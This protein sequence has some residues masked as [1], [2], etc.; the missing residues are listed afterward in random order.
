MG[1]ITR[2]GAMAL[3]LGAL[4]APALAQARTVRLVVPY[5][6]GGTTDITGR[7]IAPRRVM[8]PM[9]VS[10]LRAARHCFVI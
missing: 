5:P 9:P 4:A 1:S 3:G 8:L 7:L 6:P 10:S 2:R